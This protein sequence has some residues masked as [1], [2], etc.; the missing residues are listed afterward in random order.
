MSDCDV[1]VGGGGPAGSAA[2]A[3]LSRAGHAVT[4]FERDVFPRFHI[5]EP[6]LSSVNDVI[7]AIGAEQVVREASVQ[8]KRGATFMLADGSK[9]RYADFG[10]A[11]GVPRPQT[12]QVPRATFDQLLLR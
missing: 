12:G 11:P 4:L 2:A 6:L 7:V 5:V 1:I 8:P 10:A 3:W 9:E